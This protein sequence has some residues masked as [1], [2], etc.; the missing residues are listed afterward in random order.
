LKPYREYVEGLV[1]RD[2]S[3]KIKAGLKRLRDILEKKCLVVYQDFWGRG[4][5]MN[6]VWVKACTE[7]LSVLR[8]SDEIGP[9]VVVAS[10]F[11]LWKDR[12]YRFVSDRGFY[13]QLVRMFRSLA[14]QNTG[15]YYDH[16][17]GKPKRVYKDLSSS[18]MEYIGSTILTPYVSWVAAVLNKRNNENR[19]QEEA[20]RLFTEGMGHID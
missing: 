6:R 10:M 2:S 13:F 19:A 20:R 18:V 17:T 9:A 16:M 5:P 12:S 8:A 7:I 11:L 15:V 3:G 4:R 14:P 1:E